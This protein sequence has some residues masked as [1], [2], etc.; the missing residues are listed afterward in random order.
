[1]TD[2][3]PRL[4]VLAAARNYDALGN[5]IGSPQ[6][7]GQTSLEP[8]AAWLARLRQSAEVY[9]AQGQRLQRFHD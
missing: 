1:M 9:N 2:A 4:Q 8:D 5:L 7:A 6:A 3:S